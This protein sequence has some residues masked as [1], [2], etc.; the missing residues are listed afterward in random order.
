MNC[1][2]RLPWPLYSVYIAATATAR[3]LDRE[4]KKPVR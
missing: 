1:N 3:M 4:P 2:R